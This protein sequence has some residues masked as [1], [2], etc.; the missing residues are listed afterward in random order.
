MERSTRDG[1]VGAGML[2]QHVR[3][4]PV[5]RAELACRTGLARSTV[6][7]RVDALLAAGLVC[8][9]PGKVSTGGRPPAMITLNAGAGVILAADLRAAGARVAV[10]DLLAAPLADATVVLDLARGPEDAL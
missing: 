1:H 8:E 9:T 6:A 3:A 4:G 5:S 10:T 2:L 7:Q